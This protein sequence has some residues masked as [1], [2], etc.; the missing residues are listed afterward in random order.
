M[1]AAALASSRGTVP[2]PATAPESKPDAD[3][4]T[5]NDAAKMGYMAWLKGQCKRFFDDIIATAT[6]RRS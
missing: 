6:K 1:P 2:D 5:R 3:G 4:V